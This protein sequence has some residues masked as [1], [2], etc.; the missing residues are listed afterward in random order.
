MPE[1]RAERDERN[2]ALR[3]RPRE[4]VAQIVETQISQTGGVPGG[5]PYVLDVGQCRRPTPCRDRG[6]EMSL[7]AQSARNF[8]RARDAPMRECSG[9][10]ISSWTP[11]HQPTYSRVEQIT[12]SPTF[13]PKR[14][15]EPDPPRG[16][17]GAYTGHA[18]PEDPW[19]TRMDVEVEL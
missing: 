10:E 1:H 4:V 3:S 12:E 8:S 9:L 19:T 18:I 6:A 14:S 16:A 11:N 2:A 13:P 5:R 7:G 15:R 17:H